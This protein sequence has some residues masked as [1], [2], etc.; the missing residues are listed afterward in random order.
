VKLKNRRKHSSFLQFIMDMHGDEKNIS[1]MRWMGTL[2]VS[3][4][5]FVWT[6]SCIFDA[7]WEINFTL[8]DLPWGLV[9]VI[10]TAI[11]GKVLQSI[12]EK[13]SWRQK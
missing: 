4:I 9:A 1:W 8:E 12:G 13:G 7:G 2:L 6:L 3:N 11:G 10:T 5:M